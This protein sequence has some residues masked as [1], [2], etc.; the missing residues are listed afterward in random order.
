[1]GGGCMLV[2]QSRGGPAGLDRNSRGSSDNLS[3]AGKML[4]LL[5]CIQLKPLYEWR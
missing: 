2:G 1:M 5:L 4:L 3:A